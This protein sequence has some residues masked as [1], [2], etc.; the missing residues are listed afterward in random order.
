MKSWIRYW[1][2]VLFLLSLIFYCS[3]LTPDQIPHWDIPYLDKFEHFFVYAALGF[4]F[5]RAFTYP[6]RLVDD[7][8]LYLR[9]MIFSGLACLIWGILDEFHQSFVPGRDVELADVAADTLG[10]FFGA[11][12]SLVY[13]GIVKRFYEKRL[14]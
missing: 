7:R 8:R 10:G 14:P 13:R 2:P 12:L 5:G 6:I 1:S 11:Y 4:A 3:S 9:A